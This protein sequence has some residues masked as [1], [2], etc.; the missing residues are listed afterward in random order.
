MDDWIYSSDRKVHQRKLNRLIRLLNKNIKNDDLWDGRFFIRQYSAEFQRYGDRSGGNLFVYFRCY[1]K[2][3]MKYQEYYGDSSAL[4]HYGGSRLWWTMN[5]FITEVSSAWK[6]DEPPKDQDK[7]EYINISEDY[8]VK[9]AT[10]YYP[11]VIAA[12]W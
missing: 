7:S 5:S 11:Y 2:K 9:N 12:R 10:P 4:C 1:D 3:D 6:S 8:V